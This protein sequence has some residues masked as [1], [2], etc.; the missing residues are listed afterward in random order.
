MFPLVPPGA[1]VTI[2][3]ASL[4]GLAAGDLIAFESVR[5]VACHLFEGFEPDGR[6]RTRGIATG[7]DRPV[8]PERFV[9]RV[10]S[11]RMVGIEL[12]TDAWSYGILA[13]VAGL[14][15]PL[16]GRIAAKIWSL[17]RTRMRR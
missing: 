3:F 5:G 9:G 6:L 12:R 8:D 2:G 1:S 15:G 16:P 4:A 7:P 14:S 10:L 13:R 17:V 11:I